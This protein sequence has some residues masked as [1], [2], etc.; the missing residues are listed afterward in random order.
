[1]NPQGP[2][3]PA[4]EAGFSFWIGEAWGK[5]PALTAVKVS[6]GG[7]PAQRSPRG[8]TRARSGISTQAGSRR[9]RFP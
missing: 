8:S 9:S 2:R 3:R 6:C 5:H 7:S 1:L 4:L